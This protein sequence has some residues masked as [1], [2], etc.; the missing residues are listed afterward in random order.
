MIDAVLAVPACPPFQAQELR[1][2]SGNVEQLHT[3]GIQQRQDVPIDFGLR[4][5]TDDVG[6]TV[7]SKLLG[8][9]FPGI[10]VPRNFGDAAGF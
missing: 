6:N 7:L 5:L 4:A 1:C 3:A 2:L 8:T 9:V 10:S